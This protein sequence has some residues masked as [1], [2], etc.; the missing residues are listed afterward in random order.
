MQDKAT[1]K[2][3]LACTNIAVHSE[4][5][6]LSAKQRPALMKL[7]IGSQDSEADSIKQFFHKGGLPK[8]QVVTRFSFTDT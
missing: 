5:T 3:H 4:I 6:H 8:S 1:S 2:W 7:N